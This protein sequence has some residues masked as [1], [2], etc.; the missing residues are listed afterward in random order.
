MNDRQI[1]NITNALVKIHHDVRDRL[2]AQAKAS[3]IPRGGRRHHLVVLTG[4][5]T[6]GDYEM[7]GQRK[8]SGN[9]LPSY[10][11]DA[12]AGTLY[13][14]DRVYRDGA[15]QSE[16]HDA[17]ED[18][19]IFDLANVQVGWMKF[20]KG[21]A[22]EMVLKPVGE[23]IGERPSKDHKEGLRLLVKI[24]DDPA[25]PRELLSTSI[26]LW[27]GIDGLHTEFLA[28]LKANPGKLP[29]VA[30]ADTREVRSQDNVNFEPIFEIVKWVPRPADLPV[31]GIPAAAPVTPKSKSESKSEP[32]PKKRGSFR[33]DLDDEIPFV[34]AAMAAIPLLAALSGAGGLFA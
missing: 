32:E 19:A 23:D 13:K 20:P 30:L 22:P 12:R 15:W 9:F 3:Q 21:A 18:E 8:S 29:L 33:G 4:G 6:N 17:T 11:Y 26:A 24:P 25:G 7:L 27:H 2:R 16:Q 10:K 31:N 34:W 14:Q 1:T 28:G 5:R